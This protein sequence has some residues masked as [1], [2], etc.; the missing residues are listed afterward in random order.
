MACI[1]EWLRLNV[2]CPHCRSNVFPN[3]DLASLVRPATASAATE[4]RTGIP[5]TG[6]VFV[7]MSSG[8]QSLS[9]GNMVRLQDMLRSIQIQSGFTVTPSDAEL[10]GAEAGHV[11]SRYQDR[12]EGDGGLV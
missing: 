8:T 12:G 4:N 1:D 9:Q 7:N 10:R 6:T 5:A 2:K 3:L 11:V